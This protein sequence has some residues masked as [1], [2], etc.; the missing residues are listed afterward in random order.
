MALELRICP[1][2]VLEIR[3]AVYM[4]L[5]RMMSEVLG[6]AST[7]SRTMSRVAP[8]TIASYMG[9]FISGAVS[10]FRLPL[11]KTPWDSCLGGISD[12]HCN[13]GTTHLTLFITIRNI[14]PSARFNSRRSFWARV[15]NRIDHSPNP[16]MSSK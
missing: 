4:I 1:V 12:N 5:K 8:D 6:I 11:E 15:D 9:I 2:R 3:Y 10:G 13:Q 7:P 16:S 14:A